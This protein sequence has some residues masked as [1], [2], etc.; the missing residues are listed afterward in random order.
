V[1]YLW[2]LRHGKAASDAP[3]GGGDEERPLTGRGRR[4]ATALGAR[5]AGDPPILG[6]DEVLPPELAICSVAVRTRQTADLV[7]AALGGRLPVDAHRSL[8]GAGPDL[9][10]QYVREFDEDL[11][12]ALIV[13]HNPAMFETAWLLVHPGS[14]QDDLEGRGFPTCA[15]AVLSFESGG[16]EDVVHGS[17]TLAGLFT[18]PY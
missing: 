17:A 16:W 13:G 14:G 11:R 2:I 15:V 8:Y 18:P 9:V 1:R 5:L 12:S 7:A 3:W 6:L 4:D 10:L